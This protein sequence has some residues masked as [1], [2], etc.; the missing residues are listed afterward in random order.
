M[1]YKLCLD[2]VNKLAPVRRKRLKHPKLPPWL[3][4]NII[5]AMSDRINEFSLIIP[6]IQSQEMSA[7]GILKLTQELTYKRGLFLLVVLE[8]N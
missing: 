8:N 6:Y 1:W 2:I 4:K 5:Q 3:N 7:L